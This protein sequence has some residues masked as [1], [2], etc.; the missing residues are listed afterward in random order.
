M[1][2]LV[3]IPHVFNPLGN[4]SY[5]SLSSDPQP[6]LTA[7][8]QCLQA[9]HTL[10]SSAQIYYQYFESAQ[11]I[12]VNQANQV[13][14]TIII[15]T[16]RYLHLLN[17]IPIDKSYYQHH[18]T[19]ADPML[20]GFECHAVLKENLG[21]YDYYCYLEDDLI[22]HDPYFFQKLVW[23]N[24]HIGDHA[25]LHPNRFEQTLQEKLQKVYIDLDVNF[26]AGDPETFA[27]YF[28]ENTT[29][30][31]KILGQ[32]LTFK[33]AVNPHAGCFFLTQQQMETWANQD[34]FLDRD[35]SYFGPLESAAT[36]GIAHTFRVY[37]PAPQNANFFEIQHFG[38]VWSQKIKNVKFW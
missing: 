37:K 35:C 22:L 24:K 11:S 31:S 29:L 38:E 23:F 17:E 34:Y 12:P 21:H 1:R 13:E 16:S 8:T 33:R 14:L 10:Y 2:V 19:M 25:V 32:E 5:A 9:L 26:T 7:L 6:R 15:C 28:T 20:V 30:T 4:G 3:T 36:L 18:K 27:H